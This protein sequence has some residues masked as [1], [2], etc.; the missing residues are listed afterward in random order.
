VVREVAK[1]T[2]KVSAAFIKE[3][4]RRS[5]QFHLESDG[6]GVIAL[7]DVENALEEMLFKG[8]SLNRKL[9]GVHADAQSACD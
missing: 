5:A 8:G 1:R 9:L 2:E 6:T 4:M 7:K 3:L